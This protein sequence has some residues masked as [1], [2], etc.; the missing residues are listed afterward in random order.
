MGVNKCELCNCP[1]RIHCE[2]DQANLCWECDAKV[3]GANFLVARHSRCLLCRSCQSPTPWR[4]E[5]SRLGATVSVCQMCAATSPGSVEG[6]GERGCSTGCVEEAKEEEEGGSGDSDEEEEEEEM[7]EEDEESESGKEEDDIDEGDNQVVP[8]SP[9][10]PPVAS[11]SSSGY[12]EEESDR[13]AG[14]SGGFLKRMRENADL[15]VSQSQDDVGCSSSR[16]ASDPVASATAVA[17]EIQC[18][19]PPVGSFR[20]RKRVAHSIPSPAPPSANATL[21][22]IRVGNGNHRQGVSVMTLSAAH[23]Y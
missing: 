20:D 14:N 12:E 3:H 21:F 10:P 13:T 15:V 18:L 8:W 4:A 6:S 5:G 23:R 17:G 2:S 9:T 22:G 16:R 7:E 1:A 19:T 11:S